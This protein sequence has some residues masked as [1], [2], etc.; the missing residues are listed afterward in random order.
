MK[1]IDYLKL[2]VTGRKSVHYTL[3]SEADSALT[4]LIGYG[5]MIALA[6]TLVIG[7]LVSNPGVEL[8]VDTI[9]RP[10]AVTLALGITFFVCSIFIGGAPVLVRVSLVIIGAIAG[11][12]ITILVMEGSTGSWYPYAPSYLYLVLVSLGALRQL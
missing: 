11:I 1:Q 3:P 4:G 10:L 8:D 6:L 2:V 12:G 9:G 5:A 7:V